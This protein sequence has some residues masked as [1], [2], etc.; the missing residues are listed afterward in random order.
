MFSVRNVECASHWYQS[1]HP[2]LTWTCAWVAQRV[3][4][5]RRAIPNCAPSAFHRKRCAH[6]SPA[7]RRIKDPTARHMASGSCTE[8][9]LGPSFLPIPAPVH[10]ITPPLPRVHVIG[11]WRVLLNQPWFAFPF[12][13]DVREGGEAGSSQPQPLLMH[14]VRLPALRPTDAGAVN[15]VC[16]CAAAAW[17]AA[18][19]TVRRSWLPDDNFR[20]V[21]AIVDASVS[22]LAEFALA[23]EIGARCGALASGALAAC[24]ALVSPGTLSFSPALVTLVSA[25][26]ADALLV[27]FPLLAG[28]RPTAMPCLP[29][30]VE[31]GIF[32][33][34]LQTARCDASFAALNI[35]RVV[36]AARECV[37]VFEDASRRTGAMA[38]LG[39]LT[40]LRLDLVDSRAGAAQLLP[41][42]RAAIAFITDARAVGCS[43]ATAP[44]HPPSTARGPV[45]PES[46]VV[47]ASRKSQ[48]AS[49][50]ISTPLATNGDAV[51]VHCSAGVSRSVSIVVGYMM[52]TRR[53]KYA[54]ALARLAAEYSVHGQPPRPNDGFAEQLLTFEAELGLR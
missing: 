53:L 23:G 46:E 49:S 15:A 9:A 5:R 1:H 48:A 28:V 44:L 51:L 6:F 43:A 38:G 8:G 26:A 50:P 41:A 19:A 17:E 10:P 13:V 18:A 52:A 3:L 45:E 20:S 24:A 36:N 31:P 29:H 22:Q 2:A 21:T 27:R 4:H 47:P 11:D 7:R 40:Y 33:G 32:L 14:A 25:D 16:G 42:L 54:D 35:R 37:N 12:T 39:R 34:G 30:C